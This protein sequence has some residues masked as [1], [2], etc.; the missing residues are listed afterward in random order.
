M[1]QALKWHYTVLWHRSTVHPA[2]WA[3]LQFRHKLRAAWMESV[4][5]G[6]LLKTRIQ[7]FSVRCITLGCLPPSSDNCLRKVTELYCAALSPCPA[8]GDGWDSFCPPPRLSLELR[9]DCRQLLP[10][11]TVL[12]VST[13]PSLLPTKAKLQARRYQIKGWGRRQSKNSAGLCGLRLCYCW[14]CHLL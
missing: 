14:G 5:C 7:A 8:A 4:F 10:N 2:A 11:A 13:L 3:R 1:S 9:W 12:L 6:H